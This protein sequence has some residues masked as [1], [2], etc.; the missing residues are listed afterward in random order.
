MH[1]K[2]QI[3]CIFNNFPASTRLKNKIQTHIGY[4]CAVLDVMAKYLRQTDVPGP[5]EQTN[6]GAK[7]LA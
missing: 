6:S 3:P 2:A 7:A 5:W 1:L 4:E